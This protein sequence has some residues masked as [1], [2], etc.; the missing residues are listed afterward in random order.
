LSHI[1]QLLSKGEVVFLSLPDPAGKETFFLKE[2]FN[3][4]VYNLPYLSSFDFQFMYF[5]KANET[6]QIHE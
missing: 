5:N 1:L 2:T 4:K 3:E 6:F